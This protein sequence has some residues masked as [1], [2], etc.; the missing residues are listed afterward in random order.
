MKKLI[1]GVVAATFVA[2]P[3]ALSAGP[4]S[5]DTPRCVTLK[6]YRQVHQGMTRARVHRIFDVRG[7]SA[8]G[9]AGGYTLWYPSCRSV[10]AGGGDIGAYVTYDGW[11]DRVLEKR[12]R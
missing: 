7:E 1:L 2:A 12:F 10:R 9:G 6:E 5:A 11:T 8:G 3:I 4:A